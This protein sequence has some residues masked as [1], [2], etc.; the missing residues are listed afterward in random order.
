MQGF[1]SV[2]T[3][4]GRLHIRDLDGLM[5]VNETKPAVNTKSYYKKVNNV[6]DI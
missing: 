5:W 1:I 3:E 4:F 2:D 6:K